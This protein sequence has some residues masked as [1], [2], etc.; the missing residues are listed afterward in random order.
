MKAGAWRT[1]FY[2]LTAP[3]GGERLP[4]L[5]STEGPR[6]LGSGESPGASWKDL[7]L[8]DQDDCGGVEGAREGS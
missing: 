3:V 8:P 7:P 2:P 1:A 5:S 6:D 4:L